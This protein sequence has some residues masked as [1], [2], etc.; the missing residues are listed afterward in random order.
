MVPYDLASSRDLQMVENLQG[1]SRTYGD[2]HIYVKRQA[3]QALS[4]TVEWAASFSR[5]ATRSPWMSAR[6]TARIADNRQPPENGGLLVFVK[7][8]EE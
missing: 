2:R 6:V 8:K 1:W 4:G 7:A 5:W 3:K